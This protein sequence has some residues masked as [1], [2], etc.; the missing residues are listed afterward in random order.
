M[1]QSGGHSPFSFAQADYR[2]S[3]E[4]GDQTV[5]R[6]ISQL[7]L[8]GLAIASPIALEGQTVQYR[9]PAG[10]A[11]VSLADTGPVARAESAL[12]M[13]PK[14]VE[15]IIELGIAQSGARQ[16]REAIATFTRGVKVAPD[17]AMV[18][19]WRGH[20]YL[21]VRELD[22]AR[23]DLERGLALDSTN[24]GVL[25]HLGIVR[26]VTADFEGAAALFRRA[27]PLAPE[28]G[29]RA[30]SIDWLWM[31]LSRAGRS[32]DAQDVLER[33]T[34]SLPVENPYTRRLRLYRGLIGP[35]QV[36][37][38]ADTS[39]I[40]VATLSYGVGNW[41]LLRGDS[42]RAHE[43]FERSIHSGGWPAFGFIASEAEL[44]RSR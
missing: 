18:Y 3:P 19:R 14:S 28:A 37:A 1:T 35:E 20:R 41:Y 24:Y 30:G 42:A 39:D 8:S 36:L 25:Y 27:L 9:S 11:Y 12:A 17:N 6:V 29:E 21:S 16:Y 33:D 7:L 26:F 38:P 10:V 43:W 22:R 13:Q 2:P 5:P 32:Q 40:V 23:A 4:P 31:S 44:R 34:D 15:R